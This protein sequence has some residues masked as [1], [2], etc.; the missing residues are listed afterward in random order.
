LVDPEEFGANRDSLA[1]R[2]KEKRIASGVHYPRGLHQQPIF[3]KLY[4]PLKLPVTEKITET[5]LA[6]PV[7]HG[8][9]PDDAKTIAE[10]IKEIRLRS[11]GVTHHT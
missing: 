2:L 1:E 9:T 10:A 8:L 7:H 11:H 4:G 5:I 3:E 6:I